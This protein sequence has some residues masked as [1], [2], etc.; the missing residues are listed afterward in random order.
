MSGLKSIKRVGQGILLV[1]LAF[2]L[3]GCIRKTATITSDPPNA[4]VWVNGVYYGQ[5][6]IEM[7]YNWN[8][9]YDIKLEKPGYE[10]LTVRERFYAPIRH[11]VPFDFFTEIMPFRSHERQWRHYVLT[12]K[13]EL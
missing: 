13:K 11:W 10:P 8:W 2:C 3:S 5:T 12:P 6:P 9:F 1:A 4:K 7:A